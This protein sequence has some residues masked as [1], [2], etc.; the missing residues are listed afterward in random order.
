MGIKGMEC[1]RE[2][3][4]QSKGDIRKRILRVRDGIPIEERVHYNTAIRERV[5][6]HRSYCDAQ[7]IL[8]YASYRSEVDTMLL[9]EQ[10][11]SDGKYVF[12]PKVSDDDM[13]FWQIT[14]LE[15]LQSGYRGILEPVQGVSFPEWI[16]GRGGG[17]GRN[18]GNGIRN[19][20]N[21]N[22]NADNVSRNDRVTATV[23]MWMPGAVFDRE[24]HRIGYGKGYY[25]RYLGRVSDRKGGFHIKDSEFRLSTAALAYDCQVMRQMPCEEHDIKPDMVITEARVL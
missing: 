11:L 17:G 13:E 24:R 7:I 21:K 9:I 22:R 23:M 2:E 18:T 20:V 8:S 15:D 16:A 10:A 5:L 4:P 12:L 6:S 3:P 1:I 14:A 25:D 19:E